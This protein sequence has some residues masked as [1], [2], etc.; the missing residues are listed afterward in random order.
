MNSSLALIPSAYSA[1]KLYSVL[2]EDGTGDFDVSRNGTATYLGSDGLIK[3][4]QANEPRLEFNTDG[5]FKGVLVEPVATNLFLWSE[6]FQRSSWSFVLSPTINQEIAPDGNLT[7]DYYEPNSNNITIAQQILTLSASSTGTYYT[8]S[9]WI[10]SATGNNF[11]SSSE[12]IVASGDLISNTQTIAY[13][14]TNQWTRITR[15]IILTS[16]TNGSGSVIFRL[17]RDFQ[18]IGKNFFIWGAQLEVG[19]VATSYIPT[20]TSQVTRPADI[21]T[22]QEPTGISEIR[23]TVNGIEQA[24]SPTGGIYQLPNGHISRILMI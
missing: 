23:E 24:V 6:E 22:V 1:G 7:A 9:F 5:T 10:K 2:P 19:S 11:N 15:T 16:A 14:V 20:T 13:S 3:T 21:M 8:I 18:A 12:V 17:F 4:A